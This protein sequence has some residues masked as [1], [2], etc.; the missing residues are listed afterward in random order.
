MSERRLW[1]TCAHMGDS[2]KGG[3]A[4]L[5]L[6]FALEPLTLAQERP[7]RPASARTVEACGQSFH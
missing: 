7:S 1:I 4:C 6:C 2:A 5:A 3:S